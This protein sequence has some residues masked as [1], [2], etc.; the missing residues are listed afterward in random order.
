ML[1]DS[2]ALANHY[3]RRQLAD[4][5]LRILPTA[6]AAARDPLPRDELFRRL[7]LPPRQ[8]VVGAVG[9]LD[10]QRGYPDL[11]WAAELL[12][13][14]LRD[15]W[16]VIIGDGPRR[17]QFQRL[18]D[19]YGAQ[20]AVRFVGFRPDADHLLTAVDLLW[21]G[22]SRLGFSLPI[23]EAMSAGVPAVASDSLAT[24]ELLVHGQTGYLYPPGEVGEL[25]RTSNLLL[26]DRPRRQQL[27]RA[28]QERAAQHFS[29]EALLRDY[30]ALL[31]SLN[32]RMAR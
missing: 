25:T 22:G 13:V 8:Y 23:L 19:Q 18:R 3:R 30:E 15:V 6:V 11:I 7:R 14:A 20:D 29:V 21:H 28:A 32:S 12:R 26:L 24:R 1:T 2:H 4:Q 10:D 5:N 9:C 27:G 17:Q 16:L 31:Q